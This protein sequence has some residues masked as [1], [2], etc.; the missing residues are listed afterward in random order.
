M[1]DELGKFEFDR[2]E[3]ERP[4]RDWSCGQGMS[5]PL[6]PTTGGM[7]RAHCTPYYEDGRYFCGSASALAGKCA[8]GAL[9]DGGCSQVPPECKPARKGNAFVCTRGSC[10]QGPL[11]DGTCGSSFPPC[12]P[13]RSVMARRRMVTLLATAVVLGGVFL[14]LGLP[15]RTAF[16]SSGRLSSKHS[17]IEQ[18]CAACH[19]G[20]E[21]DLADWIHVGLA[22][23]PTQQDALC[24]A[25]HDELGDDARYP[26]SFDP[27]AL[28]KLTSDNDAKPAIHGGGLL[29][30]A[31][32][33][34]LAGP[35][36]HDERL[37]CADCHHEHHGQDFDLKRLSDAQCQVCHAG[38]F[39]SFTAGH[40]PFAD[41]PY[42]RRT[43]IYFDHETHYGRHFHE[44]KRRRLSADAGRFNAVSSQTCKECH[45]VDSAGKLMTV[46]GFET[47]CASCH[48]DQIID[49]S[50]PGLA[51]FAVPRFRIGGD[52]AGLG[53]WNEVSWR[54]L[55]AGGDVPP[56]MR[57]LLSSDE[58]FAAASR[59]LADTDLMSGRELDP[60]ESA[61]L[62]SYVAAIE[63]LFSEIDA[64]GESSVRRRLE[65][66]LSRYASKAEIDEFVRHLPVEKITAAKRQWLA[67][68]PDK[69]PAA[70]QSPP[71]PDGPPHDAGPEALKEEATVGWYLNQA[72]MS[73]RYRPTGH[74]D[75]FLRLCLDISVRALDNGPQTAG[76]S[77]GE[78][79]ELVVGA[80]KSVF[81]ELASPAA[82]GRCLKCHTTDAGST[83]SPLVNW[84]AFVPSKA[85]RDLTKF[86]HGPHIIF[87][88]DEACLKC[89]VLKRAKPAGRASADHDES[90]TIF[91]ESFF[92]PSGTISMDPHRFDS[93]F[94]PMTEA[95]CAECHHAGGVRD[96]C[97]TCHNYHATR[98]RHN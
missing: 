51:F 55:A 75:S 57:L 49:H 53:P 85:T 27:D 92:R 96:S 46:Q 70:E 73:L 3:Y 16:V 64:P 10:A 72:D 88:R 17:G 18:K 38:T 86:A 80:L 68:T 56:L 81:H 74:A 1:S 44:I 15:G 47:T 83:A 43:R 11:P 61:A 84:R 4:N 79:R 89:H 48:A 63:R 91:R 28:A 90:W 52:E 50:T 87:L 77:G 7:C 76:A 71:G 69:R 67:G 13:V 29:L 94:A 25:C 5:C 23:T 65:D 24:L 33:K 93:N 9:P 62:Q 37:A 20:G 36:S 26:H 97:T 35:V 78:Q 22:S 12:R 34:L 82:I 31:S 8:A 6:G 42:V 54:N 39:K 45:A 41:Y 2:D 59:K 95:R 32:R 66:A 19:P 58:D 60:T 98:H 40:P 21:G 14:L 30:S